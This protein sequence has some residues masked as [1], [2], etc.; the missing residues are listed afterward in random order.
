MCCV[1]LEV[2]LEN[3]L[4]LLK[5]ILCNDVMNAKNQQGKSLTFTRERIFARVWTSRYVFTCVRARLAPWEK[6][7]WWW[8]HSERALPAPRVYLQTVTL[9]QCNDYFYSRCF[10]SPFALSGMTP[11][12]P[13][14]YLR[15]CC[16]TCLLFLS[17]LST[18][19][20][21]SPFL[22]LHLHLFLPLPLSP[23]RFVHP[24]FSTSAIS[25]IFPLLFLRY[26]TF[27]IPS[28]FLP[29]LHLCSSAVLNL[30]LQLQPT[31]VTYPKSL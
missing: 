4:F 26:Y 3:S 9:M 17:S 11:H 23:V 19:R 12:W 22:L 2:Y 13:T 14:D 28:C 25:V 16:H 21:P 29:P 18:F 20:P 1:L 6:V 24:L 31:C 30:V 5:A 27:I 8:G 7:P 10:D 15:G